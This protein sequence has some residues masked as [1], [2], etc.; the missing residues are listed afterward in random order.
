MAGPVG[1]AASPQGTRLPMLNEKKI[2]IVNNRTA[3]AGKPAHPSGLFPES[4]IQLTKEVRFWKNLRF[5][6]RLSQ[7]RGQADLTTRSGKLKQRSTKSLESHKLK[8]PYQCSLHCSDNFLLLHSQRCILALDVKNCKINRITRHS[9]LNCCRMFFAA[10]GVA[11][12]R[13][14]RVLS[15]KKEHACCISRLSLGIEP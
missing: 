3:W 2:V 1:W 4:I 13:N 12:C 9:C 10:G 7:P 8:H 14:H 5:S 6:W 15:P 11:D